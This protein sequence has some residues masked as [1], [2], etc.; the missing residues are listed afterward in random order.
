MIKSQNISGEVIDNFPTYTT[1]IVPSMDRHWPV[2]VIQ[3]RMK[4]THM[5]IQTIGN[6]WLLPSWDR[7]TAIKQWRSSQTRERLLGKTKM[8]VRTKYKTFMLPLFP[9]CFSMQVKICK[10]MMPSGQSLAV[11]GQHPTQWYGMIQNLRVPC[12]IIIWGSRTGSQ[13]NKPW[14]NFRIW[15]GIDCNKSKLKFVQHNDLYLL[16]EL[17]F[18][19]LFLTGTKAT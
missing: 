14:Y 5:V 13:R 18:W 15:H 4:V 2:K 1:T 9:G 11:L 8:D 17:E 10:I 16:F 12:T 6:S 19:Y 7:H 3:G